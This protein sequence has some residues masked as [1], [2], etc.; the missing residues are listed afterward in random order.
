MMRR[1][2]PAS[3]RP[4]DSLSAKKFS[5]PADLF[6][7]TISLMFALSFLSG[8]ASANLVPLLA[9]LWNS[10]LPEQFHG[11][12]ITNPNQHATVMNPEISRSLRIRREKMPDNYRQGT[13]IDIGT[14]SMGLGKY[15]QKFSLFLRGA[16]A[17][18]L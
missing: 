17:F 4:Q 5:A 14:S 3:L 10:F 11:A 8:A 12:G 18:P 16:R 6:E 13:S 7:L 9:R 2:L 1:R 15:V